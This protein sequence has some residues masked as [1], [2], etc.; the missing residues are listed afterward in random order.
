[1]SDVEYEN[2]PIPDDKP[3]EEYTYVERRAELY[4]LIEKNGHPRNIEVTQAELGKKYGVSQ[5]T[6]SNDFEKLREYRRSRVGERAISSTEF[7]AEKAV[8]DAIER[9][10]TDKALKLQLEYN[11]WLF[12]LGA[13]EE[14]PD[15]LEVSGDPG[16]AYMEMLRQASDA[17]G[18]DGS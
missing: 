12:D 17:D 3:R 10:D 14:S 2:I 6:I 5:R 16:E 1:M 4:R 11:R 18:G 13:L 7:I 15:K 9:G 8:R